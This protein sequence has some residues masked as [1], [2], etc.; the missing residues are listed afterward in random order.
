MERDITPDL[1]VALY[2]HAL[3]PSMYHFEQYASLCAVQRCPL[4]SS[5]SPQP[6]N[7]QTRGSRPGG[8]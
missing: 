4:T 3:C 8:V 2:R 5:C 1:L 6:E 7:R